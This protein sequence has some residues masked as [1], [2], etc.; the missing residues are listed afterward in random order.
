MQE[1][2]Q[3]NFISISLYASPSKREYFFLIFFLFISNFNV[4][5]F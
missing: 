4:Y 5:M 2:T 1:F 3:D